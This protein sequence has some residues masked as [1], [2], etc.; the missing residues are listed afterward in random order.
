M[1]YG[2]GKVGTGLMHGGRVNGTRSG[3]RGAWLMAGA[4]WVRVLCMEVG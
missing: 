1:A 4:K 3:F 2:W